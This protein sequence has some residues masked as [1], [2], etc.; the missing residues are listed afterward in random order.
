MNASDIVRRQ[1]ALTPGAAA[2]VDARGN[3]AT[4][5]L[6]AASIDAVAHRI[7]AAGIVPQSVAVL[8]TRDLYKFLV[9]AMAL[10]RAGVVFAPPSLPVAST[11]VALLDE[12]EAGDGSQQKPS[13]SMHFRRAGGP[14]PEPFARIRAAPPRSRCSPPR[15]LRGSRGSRRSPRS[16]HPALRPGALRSRRCRRPARR[17]S[18]QASCLGPPA[19]SGLSTAML[20]L[21]SAAPSRSRR[22][23][24]AMVPWLVA[25]GIECLV[26]SPVVSTPGACGA[27]GRQANALAAVE[28]GGGA[29]TP[30][31][32]ALAQ[33]R[34]CPN[35]IIGYR[36]TEK[37]RVG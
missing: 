16:R 9:T 17:S 22:D 15:E 23:E 3:V 13:R 26:L 21:R 8:A 24:A 34:L 25:S 33:E 18:R 30:Q 11:D 7:R 12:G 14:A 6:L 2:F 27:S 19:G 4:Y 10:A 31:V 36:T 29:L 35:V 28:V 20:T 5:T 32:R 1:A 37:G